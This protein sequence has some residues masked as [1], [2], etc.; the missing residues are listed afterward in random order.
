MYDC[1]AEGMRVVQNKVI[2]H[3]SFAKKIILQDNRPH[4]L[5]ASVQKLLEEHVKPFHKPNVIPLDRVKF[6]LRILN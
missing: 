4:E 2:N 5:Q 6:V 1:P 3:Y